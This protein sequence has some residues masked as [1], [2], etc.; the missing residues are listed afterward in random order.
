MTVAAV[1]LSATTEGAIAD[2]LGQ[3]RVRRIVDIAWSGGALPVVV[4]A[5][6]PDGTVAAALVGAEASSGGAGP[7][8]IGPAGQMARGADIAAA[9]VRGTTGVL[10]WPAR[11]AWVGPETVTSLIESHGMDPSSILRPAWDGEPG[12]P[13][14]LPAGGVDALRAV[15]PGLAPDAVIDAVGATIAVHVL[16]LG[17]PG[18]TIDVDTPFDSLPPYEGPPE[19]PAGHTHEWGADVVSETGLSAAADD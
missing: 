1:I 6:D 9:E 14:V 8:E 2:T 13:V 3:P 19:P 12:W 5:P 4:C 18:T 16:D 11:L 7:E 10:L 15:D 17:D